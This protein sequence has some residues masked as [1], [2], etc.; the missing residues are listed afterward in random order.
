MGSL[1]IVSTPIGNLND[2][3]K[4]AE[5]IIKQVDFVVCEDTRKT[6]NLIHL[7]FKGDVKKEFVSY[8]EHN[9]EQKIPE[10]IE[11]LEAGMNIALISDSGTPL[12]SDPGYKLVRECILR[13]IKVIPIPGPSSVLAALTISGLPTD[14][15]MFLGFLPKADG[16][17]KTLLS[18]LKKSLEHISF[19]VVIFESPH[20]LV[21]TLGL[22]N[23]VFGDI[24]IVIC[25]EITKIHEEVKRGKISELLE[26]LTNKKIKGEVVLLFNLKIK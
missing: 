6:G 15:F 1:Y 2:I 23:E 20:K 26:K 18:N 25:R 19:T 21:K 11:R 24:N 10:I 17:K 3:T 7:L 9:E 16:K 14:K 12:I 4:R 5:E 22:V 8:F 13:G